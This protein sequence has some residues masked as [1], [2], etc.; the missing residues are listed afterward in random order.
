M[1]Q[2]EPP[3]NAIDMKPTSVKLPM[4]DAMAKEYMYINSI[5]TLDNSTMISNMGLDMRSTP[6]ALL[7]RDSM[8]MGNNR[9]MGHI[10]MMMVVTTVGNGVT[11]LNMVLAHTAR[12]N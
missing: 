7:M 9:V 2:G 3:S 11:Q 10:G 6:M 4:G 8:L 12:G 1:P 5:T